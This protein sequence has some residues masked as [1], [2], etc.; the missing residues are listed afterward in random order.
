MPGYVVIQE[1]RAF[2]RYFK[3][4]GSVFNIEVSIFLLIVSGTLIDFVSIFSI[5]DNIFFLNKYF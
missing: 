3:F 4:K 1:I 5:L 2:K